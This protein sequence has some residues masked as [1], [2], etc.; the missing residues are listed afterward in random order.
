MYHEHDPLLLKY[1][2]PCNN[3]TAR[4]ELLHR[5]SSVILEEP[6]EE[7]FVLIQDVEQSKPELLPVCEH[8]NDQVDTTMKVLPNATNEEARA[9]T[10]E[11]VDQLIVWHGSS[12]AT[13]FQCRGWSRSDNEWTRN[14]EAIGNRRRDAMILKCAEDPKFRTRLC[15]HWDVSKGTFCPMRKKNK[16]IF[17]HSAVELRVKPAKRHRWGKLVDKDGNHKNV[18]ASGG[19]DTYGAAR[20]IEVERKQEG[21][22]NTDRGGQPKGKRLPSGAASEIS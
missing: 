22:W 6:L 5:A 8:P 2:I 16:C 3:A 12:A 10:C 18:N 11:Q 4:P 21:K 13:A 19:E 15:N 17:A 14:G 7:E 1:D 20:A 9:D